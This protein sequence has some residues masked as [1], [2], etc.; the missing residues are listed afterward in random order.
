MQQTQTFLFYDLETY[1]LHP[2]VDRITQFACVRT[3]EDLVPIGEPLVL[4]CKLTEDYLPEIEA[5]LVHGITPK[6]VMENGISEYE[7]AKKIHKEFSIPNTCVVGYNNIRF[8]DEFIRNLFYRNFFDPYYREWANGNSRW[9]IID[10][11]RLVHDLR[12]EGINWVI[13]EDNKPSFRLE[14]LTVANNLEHA[15][16]HDALSD[17]YAT[18]ALLKLIKEMQPKTFS[19]FYANRF[20]Q[21]ILKLVYR[22]PEDIF[23]HT[24]NMFTSVNGCT[25]L[26]T[27]L[28]RHP[29]NNNCVL[30]YDLRYSPN[31]L[32]NSST[33]DIEKRLFTRDL[34]N[35]QRIH[36]KGVHI[37]KCP[38]VAPIDV[39]DEA[40]LKRLNID[41]VTCKDNLKLIEKNKEAIKEKLTII[42]EKEIDINV[43]EIDPERQI[44]S[45]GFFDDKDKQML[46]Q[47]HSTKPEKL[48]NLKNK[49]LDK[50]ISELLWRFV[51]RNFP[52]VLSKEDSIKWKKFCEDRLINPMIDE[53][54]DIFVY[55]E[56]LETILSG[57]LS[58]RD[59]NVLSSLSSY[60]NS[61]ETSLK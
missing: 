39:V 36:V 12:P 50:R 6:F 40:S 45:G 25:T 31:E 52:E 29:K 48:L 57:Q 61:L 42:Y 44:Y 22:S 4:F 27:P 5:S 18:I 20:K 16:A 26:M 21:E 56:K 43:S 2:Q 55:K 51:A 8:D 10:L 30:A 17:V 46:A 3:N 35:E 53:K 60:V 14:E 7:F 49:F 58:E 34:A 41:I 23:V 9:D 13:N 47:I 59:Q 33:I 15:D 54:P 38:I 19:F 28:M 11:I 32:I 1:G 24:S 37:N